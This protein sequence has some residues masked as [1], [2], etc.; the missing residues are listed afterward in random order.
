MYTTSFRDE[1]IIVQSWIFLC[2]IKLKE[3]TSLLGIQKSTKDRKVKQNV[4][5][6]ITSVLKGFGKSRKKD[7]SV[8]RRVI[9][10]VIVPSS[11][12]RDCLTQHMEKVMGT[13]RKTVYKHRQLWLQ[14]DANDELSCWT[15]ISRQ[16]YKDRLAENVKE[17][18]CNCWLEE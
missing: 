14:I 9:Q 13:S 17:L 15:V 10:I 12:T 8:A 16:P 2:L 7:V 4:F 5:D 18:A 3:A 11:N 1:S 6:N